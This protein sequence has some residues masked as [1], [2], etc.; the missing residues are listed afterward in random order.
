MTKIKVRW[1]YVCAPTDPH[2]FFGDKDEPCA[3]CGGRFY[4]ASGHWR[5]P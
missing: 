4:E 3:R 2:P 5:K 1:T